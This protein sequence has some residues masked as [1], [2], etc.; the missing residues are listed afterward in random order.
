MCVFAFIQYDCLC[1][2][3]YHYCHCL[4]FAPLTVC[5]PNVNQIN[6]MQV[7][8]SKSFSLPCKWLSKRSHLTHIFQMNHLAS[9]EIII[10][11]FLC[12][13]VGLLG[14]NLWPNSWEAYQQYRPVAFL[15]SRYE[16]IFIIN[17]YHSH[18][19]FAV[20]NSTSIADGTDYTSSHKSTALLTWNTLDST[21][22]NSS[23]RSR[24]LTHNHPVVY[25][26]MF[27]MNGIVY[28]IGES[29]LPLP[30]GK[31]KRIGKMYRYYVTE[32]DGR[33]L[34]ETVKFVCNSSIL[35]NINLIVL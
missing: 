9:N 27:E 25:T 32:D 22:W 18:E 23:W 16:L 10:N 5:S 15:P 35:Y 8:L 13:Q 14:G 21:S 34:R 3:E 12:A 30:N 29:R 24:V 20:L 2:Y 17:H 7:C 33:D 4:P 28:A 31:I 11:S 26:G 1:I 6:Y 19:D